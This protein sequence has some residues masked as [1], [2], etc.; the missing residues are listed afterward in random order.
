MLP[1][2]KLPGFFVQLRMVPSN[3]VADFGIELPGHAGQD[4]DEAVGVGRHEVDRRFA[5]TQLVH[6]RCDRQPPSAGVARVTQV[7]AADKTHHDF[8]FLA[9]DLHQG[10]V[11]A[12]APRLPQPAPVVLARACGH[13]RMVAVDRHVL[14][15]DVKL[16]PFN[17][18]GDKRGDEVVDV[19]VGRDQYGKGGAVLVPAPASRGRLDRFPAENVGPEHS[20]EALWALTHHHVT[21][22]ADGVGQPSDCI[23]Q[24]SHVGLRLGR[25]R[26]QDRAHAQMSLHQGLDLDLARA[27]QHRGVGA[28]VELDGVPAGPPD[29]RRRLHRANYESLDRMEPFT[30]R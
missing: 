4:I 13:A 12:R 3:P 21:A 28:H 6:R 18:I 11:E 1:A 5:D 24:R 8:A 16:V 9:F 19:R 23:E 17:L 25:E 30:K 2:L 15:R 20:L 10:L 14:E 29:F 22:A 7:G 27:L 26:V